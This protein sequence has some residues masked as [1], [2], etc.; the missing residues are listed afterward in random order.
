MRIFL[1]LVFLISMSASPTF[2]EPRT[3]SRAPLKVKVDHPT[4]GELLAWP[5][6]R[7]GDEVADHVWRV[8]RKHPYL[9]VVDGQMAARLDE[10]RPVP[11][12][13]QVIDNTFTAFYD[14]TETRTIVFRIRWREAKDRTVP[15]EISVIAYRKA[16][17]RIDPSERL[18]ACRETWLGV[19]QLISTNAK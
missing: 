10:A 11:A 15:V 9:E 14:V 18:K 12:H 17:D 6:N 3:E 19:G 16:S 2:G 8:V 5:K 7:C 4:D 13:R 1:A